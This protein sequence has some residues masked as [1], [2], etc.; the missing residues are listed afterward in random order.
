MKKPIWI[1][2]GVLAVAGVSVYIYQRKFGRPKVQIDNVDWLT[3]KAILLINGKKMELDKLTAINA[4]GYTVTYIK[5][6]VPE[7]GDQDIS[8]IVVKKGDS[9]VDTV[10]N[11]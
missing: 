10:V 1:I 3:G 8:G 7:V 9:I 11:R 2:L 5:S 4:N 6:Y